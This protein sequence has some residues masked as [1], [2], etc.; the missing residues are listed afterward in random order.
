MC[1][2]LLLEAGADTEVVCCLMRTALDWACV[3]GNGRAITLLLTY[4]ADVHGHPA[5]MLGTPL[6][7]AAE[8]HVE[9]ARELLDWG[10]S[11]DVSCI[12][13][14]SDYTPLMGA[15]RDGRVA[16]ARLLLAYGA[17]RAL[18]PDPL[19]FVDEWDGSAEWEELHAPTAHPG[20]K[21]AAYWHSPAL[22]LLR[23]TRGFTPLH[24]LDVQTAARTSELLLDGMSP[25]VRAA[26][27]GAPSALEMAQRIERDGRASAGSPAALVLC[28]WRARL[29]AL[30]MGTHARLGQDSPVRHLSGMRELF[31]LITVQ[32]ANA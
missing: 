20:E 1:M 15:C 13:Y 29:T 14:E 6:L 22:Q 31:E 4:G 10:A 7:S 23:E 24:F 3:S 30:A 25:L 18:L 19:D 16:M 12:G 32:L 9:A 26:T 11:V 17:Q 28:W 5:N 2:R 21:Y 8:G 27:S